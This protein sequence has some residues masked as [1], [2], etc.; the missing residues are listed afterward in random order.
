MNDHPAQRPHR[1]GIV[2]KGAMVGALAVATS[3]GCEGS[4]RSDEAARAQSSADSEEPERLEG[5]YAVPKQGKEPNAPPFAAAEA[6]GEQDEGSGGLTIGHAAGPGTAQGYGS[7]AGTRGL[8]GS[9]RLLPSPKPAMEAPVSAN[10]APVEKAKV[11]E[12]I[13]LTDQILDPNGRYATTYRPGGGHLAAFESAV[14]LGLVPAAEREIVS[15][16]GAR[17]AP[18]ID[19]PKDTTLSL[20]PE[21]ERTKLAPEGGTV[22]LR[23]SLRST[24]EAAAGRPPLAVVVVMDTSGSMRGELIQNA[25]AAASK[26]VDKLDEQ[27]QFS[28]VRFSSDAQ[29]LVPMTTIGSKRQATKDAIAAI[30]EGGG[31]NI[32]EGLRLGYEQISKK[33]VRKD[34]VRVVML[35]S[36]GRAN[37]GT[38]DRRRLAGQALHAFEDGIQTSTFGL[39]TDY[40]GPLMSQIANDGAGGYYYLPS[41]T[42]ITSALATEIDKRLEPVATAVEVRV[43]LKPGVDLL[44][45]YGSRRLSAEEAA[46]VRVVEVAA[47]KQA[48]KRDKI[49]TNR[50]ND[51]EGGMRFFM[52]AFARDD[53]HSILLKLRV[54]EGVGPKDLALVEL[55][56]K[57]RVRKKNVTEEQPLRVEYANSDTES[58]ASIDPSVRRTV[59]G[60]AAGETL[61]KAAQL[62]ADGRRQE[63]IDLLGE[64]EGLLLHAAATLG[65]PLFVQDAN[66]LSRLRMHAAGKD[67]LGDSLVLAM[68]MESAGGVHLR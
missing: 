29:V 67:K 41:P 42:Q 12:A 2:A 1:L 61:T 16:V 30:T 58:V 8:G 5:G 6:K 4:K 10:T 55:K 62:V 56:Y 54:P 44:N 20:L 28:I 57:D 65:E 46:R 35:L 60:F 53:A 17:Y 32:S 23:L 64:R 13:P 40:D 22:H 18:A 21:L 36:D 43:R 39:G 3:L 47:D 68:M 31:T 45:V 50:E 27:D 19:A 59:Q 52:P 7:G 51:L 9:G 24:A 11:A 63:A 66:R 37:E 26:L 25:R 33:E 49:K 48:E 15:D 14:A 38:T 34:A